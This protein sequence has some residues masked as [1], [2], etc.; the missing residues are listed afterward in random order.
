M[1]CSSQ[2]G[3]RGCSGC[4][5]KAGDLQLMWCVVPAADTTSLCAAHWECHSSRVMYTYLCKIH[6]QVKIFRVWGDTCTWIIKAGST[7]WPGNASVTAMTWDLLNAWKWPVHTPN[8]FWA[9]LPS[10]PITSV[11]FSSWIK[12]WTQPESQLDTVW[13]QWTSSADFQA[14]PLVKFK[15]DSK[16]CKCH[17]KMSSFKH[18]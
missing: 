8:S 10:H 7:L 9:L 13:Q 1:V 14:S 3:D 17:F 15:S 6:C 2:S 11:C 4:K 12:P 16:V 5:V 18:L